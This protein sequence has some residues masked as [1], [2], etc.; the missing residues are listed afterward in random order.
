MYRGRIIEEH[1]GY[2]GH[3]TVKARIVGEPI[4]ENAVGFRIERSCGWPSTNPELRI[5]V[6]L[7]R[8][9]Q[10]RDLVIEYLNTLIDQRD[11]DATRI[12]NNADY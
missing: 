12:S 10:A 5:D 11:V 4:N 1:I 7:P 2:T 8:L 3:K 9:D 6:R